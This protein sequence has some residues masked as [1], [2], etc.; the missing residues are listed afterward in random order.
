[1]IHSNQDVD[2]F[3]DVCKWNK[4]SEEIEVGMDVRG[5]EILDHV[6]VT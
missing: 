2:L 3:E 6:S 4:N 5:K 1:M